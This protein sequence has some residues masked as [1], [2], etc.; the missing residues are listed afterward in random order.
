[1]TY[2]PVQ[3]GALAVVVDN[4]KDNASEKVDNRKNNVNR[5][6]GL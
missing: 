2:R 5:G 1:M 4:R 3:S 6:R